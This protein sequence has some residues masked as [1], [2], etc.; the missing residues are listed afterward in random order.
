MIEMSFN[1]RTICAD[2]PMDAVATWKP[3]MGTLLELVLCR[4]DKELNEEVSRYP[5]CDAEGKAARRGRRTTDGRSTRRVAKLSGA[6][7][8]HRRR[9]GNRIDEAM[10]CCGNDS[11]KYDRYVGQVGQAETAGSL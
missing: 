7:M 6:M 10:Y 9:K 2:I 5:G 4:R 11:E 1:R 8:N 3:R